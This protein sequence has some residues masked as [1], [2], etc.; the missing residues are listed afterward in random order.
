MLMCRR[1]GPRCAGHMRAQLDAAEDHAGEVE[2]RIAA[3]S[4][5]AYLAEARRAAAIRRV[6]RAQR[7]YDQTRQGIADRIASLNSDPDRDGPSRD[8]ERQAILDDTLAYQLQLAAHRKGVKQIA[9]E[10]GQSPDQVVSD[11]KNEG[12]FTHD[13]TR[14]MTPTVGYMVSLP[15][16]ERKIRMDGKSAR[17]LAAS[18]RDYARERREL[19]RQ[20]GNYVGGW[21]NPDNGI[22]Y[23][24][25][26]RVETDV[27]SAR[28]AA[29]ENQQEAFYDKQCGDEVFVLRGVSETRDNYEGEG[30]QP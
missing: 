3:G 21:V 10:K 26:S 12:G 25:V 20:P 7:N 8:P 15:G 14:G 22:L 13:F 11:I 16:H 19:L 24:D 28:A 27:A 9:A 17:D 23:L 5:P 30:E 6:A 1:G 18:I 4:I 29:I 2:E